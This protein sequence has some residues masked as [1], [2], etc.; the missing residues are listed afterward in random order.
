MEL[1]QVS[2]VFVDEFASV[3]IYLEAA[4]VAC[5]D[6]FNCLFDNFSLWHIVYL[7]ASSDCLKLLTGL[8]N[9]TIA[10]AMFIAKPKILPVCPN[11]AAKITKA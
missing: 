6:F 8:N 9:M 7:S 11:I 1:K 10:I 5:P 3:V 2:F 4:L